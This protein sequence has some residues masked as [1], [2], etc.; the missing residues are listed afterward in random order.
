MKSFSKLIS[1]FALLTLATVSFNAYAGTPLAAQKV[2]SIAT[3]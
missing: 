3:G 1:S 2:T